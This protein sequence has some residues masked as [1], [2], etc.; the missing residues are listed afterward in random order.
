MKNPEDLYLTK[1]FY[2]AYLFFNEQLFDGELRIVFIQIRKR[3]TNRILGTYYVSPT[4]NSHHIININKKFVYDASLI[5]LVHEMTHHWRETCCRK[6][7]S[8]HHDKQFKD[9][10]KSFGFVMPEQIP[11]ATGKFHV[12]QCQ[13]FEDIRKIACHKA[14]LVLSGIF[15]CPQCGAT[16]VT[17]MDTAPV[18]PACHRGMALCDLGLEHLATDA[19]LDAKDYG[20]AAYCR[21]FLARYKS[22]VRSG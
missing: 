5:T 7:T 6:K 11:V 4:I 21:H 14:S 3:R 13:F 20:F 15:I 17:H 16:M 9:K 1:L 18:C 10:M 8:R 12:A 2:M 22:S 19:A